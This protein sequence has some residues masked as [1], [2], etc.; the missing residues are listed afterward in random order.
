MEGVKNIIAV[1][2]GKGGGLKLA[3]E[4]G[5]KLLGQVPLVMEVGENAEKGL[6]IFSQGNT[7]VV[8]AFTK[9][10]EAVTEEKE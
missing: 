4:L 5:T 8:E 2:S 3:K 1:A 7:K 10:S 6:S 9:I